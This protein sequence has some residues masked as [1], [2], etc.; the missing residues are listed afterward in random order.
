MSTPDG[1]GAGRPLRTA[2]LALLAIAGISLLIAFVTWLDGGGNG[3]PSAGGTTTQSPAAPPSTPGPGAT[4]APAPGEAAPGA[5]GGQGEPA[6][7]GQPGAGQPGAD[8]PGGAGAPSGPGQPGGPGTPGGPG[9]PGGAGPGEPG[10]VDG[11]RQPGDGTA[12]QPD[13][14]ARPAPSGDGGGARPAGGPKSDVERA[15]LRVYNNSYIRG[16][17]ARAAEDFRSEGWRVVEV[18]NY[19]GGRIPTSTVY[20]QRGTDQRGAAEALGNQFGLRVEPRFAGIRDAAPG[21]LVIVT[22]DY[23]D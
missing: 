9:Q 1:T 18:G 13:G 12:A 15:E 14:E 21:V 10:G 20:Y 3:R 7:P 5:P 22:K 16:L 11:A 23:G 4:A 17:A 2:G 6:A 8:Q 19:S